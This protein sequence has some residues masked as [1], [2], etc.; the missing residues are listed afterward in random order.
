MNAPDVRPI[1]SA[2]YRADPAA[3]PFEKEDLEKMTKMCV[4]DPAQTEYAAPIIISPKKYG[5]LRFCVD[6]RKLN[7]VYIGDA[8]PIPRTDKCNDS[9][10]DAQLFSTLDANCGYCQVEVEEVD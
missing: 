4:I 6:Y 9:F 1:H 3:R 10:A 7:A 8:Y 5:S 2:P